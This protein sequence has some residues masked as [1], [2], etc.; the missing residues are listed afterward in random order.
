[1]EIKLS[2]Q[3]SFASGRHLMAIIRIHLMFYSLE[4]ISLYYSHWSVP[5]VHMMYECLRFQDNVGISAHTLITR[6]LTCFVRTKPRGSVVNTKSL[7]FAASLMKDK[8]K[9]NEDREL[10]C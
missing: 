6:T 9:M 2:I 10:L 4:C 5:E 8:R 1:M 7:L 3:R